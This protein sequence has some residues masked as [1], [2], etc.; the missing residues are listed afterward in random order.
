MFVYASDPT[1]H[2]T[3]QHVVANSI[4]KNIRKIPHS[5][6]LKLKV[7]AIRDTDEVKFEVFK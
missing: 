4:E 3:D 1:F 2:F 7:V 6:F 5:E